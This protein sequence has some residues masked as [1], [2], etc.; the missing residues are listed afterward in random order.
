V[1]AIESMPVTF[2]YCRHKIIR[3][4]SSEGCALRTPSQTSFAG[5][6]G[7]T[8]DGVRPL[9]MSQSLGAISNSGRRRSASRARTDLIQGGAKLPELSTNRVKSWNAAKLATHFLALAL[10]SSFVTRSYAE[11]PPGH[12]TL[13]HKPHKTKRQFEIGEM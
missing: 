11:Q 10:A 2:T 6:L 9:G 1:I 7:H 3:E 13:I 5:Q 12:V 4:E 8:L